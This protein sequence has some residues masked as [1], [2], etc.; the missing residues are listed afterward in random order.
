MPFIKISKKII[1][2][3]KKQCLEFHG[4]KSCK[5]CMAKRGITID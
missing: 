1:D 2:E 4:V 5:E 3:S